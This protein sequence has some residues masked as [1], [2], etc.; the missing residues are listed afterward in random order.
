MITEG[1]QH[2]VLPPVSRLV[3]LKFNLLPCELSILLVCSFGLESRGRGY[4]GAGLLPVNAAGSEG[5]IFL[6]S[7]ISKSVLCH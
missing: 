1:F 7:F 2:S 4:G 3:F 6:L 5:C